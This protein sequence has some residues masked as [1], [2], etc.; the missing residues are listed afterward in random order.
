MQHQLPPGC[1]HCSSRQ[2]NPALGWG[3]RGAGRDSGKR[4]QATT[5]AASNFIRRAAICYAVAVYVAMLCET[6]A[7]CSCHQN[8]SIGLQ[9]R[10]SNAA[11]TRSKLQIAASSHSTG[12][13]N[14]SRNSSCNRS[15]HKTM[16]YH[17]AKVAAKEKSNQLLMEQQQFEQPYAS[18]AS[19]CM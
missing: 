18:K 10:M 12:D 19:Q 13:S 14:G 1:E 7:G 15:Q 16:L 17:T 3:P 6:C 9:P 11:R 4:G 2:S 8:T 5:A